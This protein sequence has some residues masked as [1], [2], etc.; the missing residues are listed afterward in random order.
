MSTISKTVIVTG[1]GAGIGRCIAKTYATEGAKVIVAE[2]MKL[3]V[4]KLRLK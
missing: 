1:A 3:Q 2:K 4:P